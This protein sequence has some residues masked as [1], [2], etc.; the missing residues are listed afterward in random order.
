MELDISLNKIFDGLR[1]RHVRQAVRQP[2]HLLVVDPECSE[3]GGGGL[4][5]STHLED[6]EQRPILKKIYDEAETA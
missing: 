4:E 6:L 3:P 1:L 2:L 5:E